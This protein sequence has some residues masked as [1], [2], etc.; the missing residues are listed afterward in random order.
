MKDKNVVEKYVFNTIKTKEINSA[1]PRE[2][3]F[4]IEGESTIIKSGIL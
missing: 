1:I 4:L 2:V 3:T